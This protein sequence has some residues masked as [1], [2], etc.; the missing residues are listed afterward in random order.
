M[1]DTALNLCLITRPCNYLE[2][3]LIILHDMFCKYLKHMQFLLHCFGISSDFN[4]RSH[5]QWKRPKPLWT[6]EGP[7]SVYEM[8]WRAAWRDVRN[9]SALSQSSQSSRADLGLW[10]LH[11]GPSINTYFGSKEMRFCVTRSRFY[12]S[13]PLSCFF[14][15]NDVSHGSLKIQC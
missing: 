2:T 4:A 8:L 9:A 14:F 11:N 12:H 5:P 1:D 13:G 10:P 6:S 15:L 7:S 3:S